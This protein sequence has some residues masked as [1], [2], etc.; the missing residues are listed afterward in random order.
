MADPGLVGGR[1]GA[2]LKLKFQN[3][4]SENCEFK[5]YLK[6]LFAS[7]FIFIYDH[8]EWKYIYVVILWQCINKGTLKIEKESIYDIFAERSKARIFF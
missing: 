2:K 3:Q 6:V 4:S 5:I 1:G 8:K 7:V